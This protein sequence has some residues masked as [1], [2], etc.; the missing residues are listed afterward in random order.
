MSPRPGSELIVDTFVVFMAD[1][2]AEG[3]ALGVSLFLSVI[4]L[5]PGQKHSQ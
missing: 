4:E 5:I 3:A 1:N 2:G